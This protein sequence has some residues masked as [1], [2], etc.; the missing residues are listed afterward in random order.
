MEQRTVLFDTHVLAHGKMVPFA[1]WDMPIHYGSQLQEHHAV[2]QGVGIFDVSHM[3]IMDLEGRDTQS[4]LMNLLANDVRKI[5]TPGGALYSC[6]LNEQ[7]GIIDDLIVYYLAKNH[8][9]IVF[10]AST[11]DTVCAWLT[12]HLGQ[13][14]VAI[15]LRDDDAM[16]A[17]QGPK[18]LICMSKL[19]SRPQT[20]VLSSLKSF[21]TLA[22][23]D[24]FIARTGYTG[25]DG[26][27]V[28]LPQSKAV[29]FWNRAVQAG[30]V[31]CGLGARD[32][33]RL[34]AGLNLFGTDMSPE[35]TPV[36]SNLTWTVSFTDDRDFIGKRALLALAQ[37][38]H[39]LLM[40]IVLLGKGVLRN[41]LSVT[42]GDMKGEITSGSFSP[43]L[44]RG[45]AMAR[46]PQGFGPLC[47]VWI[48]DKPVKGQVVPLPFVR[49]GRSLISA[50]LKESC[51]E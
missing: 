38:P 20:D 48:R 13:Q 44:G 36:D 17:I 35:H 39:E 23:G 43:T 14:K 11:R 41:H 42:S 5:A 40:G 6:M 8:Y 26:F 25:E 10:N 15:T 29:D 16:I 46:V 47:E 37:K 3:T 18:A 51:D 7:G 33:L 1:G 50:L 49:K 9:R 2:R 4:F 31:P 19:M 32:T 28:M 22:D 30:A 24:I 21:K 12:S 45:I 34:E 27:E